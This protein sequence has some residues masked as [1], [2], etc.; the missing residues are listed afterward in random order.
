MEVEPEIFH[1]TRAK[2]LLGRTIL[3]WEDERDQYPETLV[4][5]ILTLFIPSVQSPVLEVLLP[6]LGR[7]YCPGALGTSPIHSPAGALGTS[8]IHSPA[9]GHVPLFHL[10]ISTP[11]PPPEAA[12]LSPR[13]FRNSMKPSV[14]KS[15]AV[16]L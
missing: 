10:I 7:T 6:S 4:L 14:N 12:Y 13:P 5:G 16:A 9:S 11:P 3:R 8:P 2:Q 1:I 15:P